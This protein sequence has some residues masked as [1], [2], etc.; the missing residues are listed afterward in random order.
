MLLAKSEVVHNDR[1][2][3]RVWWPL[4]PHD[5]AQPPHPAR[6]QYFDLRLLARR[7]RPRVRPVAGEFAAAAMQRLSCPHR[8]LGKLRARHLP[9]TE[10]R[11]LGVCQLHLVPPL[12]DILGTP[13]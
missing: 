7:R 10:Q 13:V 1:F 8:D 6:G 9:R 3:W 5:R 2:L 11:T 12:G 4:G